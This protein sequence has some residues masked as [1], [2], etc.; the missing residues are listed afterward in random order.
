MNIAGKFDVS[1]PL[2]ILLIEDSEIDATLTLRAL[3]RGGFEPTHRR[4]QAAANVE[5]ALAQER[6]DAVISDFNMP[7]FSGLD[8]LAMFRAANLN[9][10]FI[11]VSGNIS[12]ETAVEAMKAGASDY[13]M[14]DKLARLAPALER[15]LKETQMRAAH[16]R[17]QRE[18]SESEERFREM[19]ENIRDVF[20]LIDAAS[21]RVLYI[22]PAYTG[23]W[24]R[25]PD[26]VYADAD[27]WRESIHPQ[28]RESTYD[29]FRKGMLDG[30]LEYEYRIVRPDGSIRWIETQGFPVRDSTGSMVRVAG[31][32]KDIT[33]RKA[34]QDRITYLNRVYAM[35]SGINTLIVRVRDRHELFREACR[36][37]VDACGFRMAWIAM[38]DR[39][40]MKVVPVASA[41]VDDE[42]LIALKDRYAMSERGSLGNTRAARAIS[43]GT[44]I[45]TNEVANNTS[46]A[47]GRKYA[48]RGIGSMAMLPLIV[49]GQAVGAL[50][51]YAHESAFFH[52]EE[53]KLLSDL[54]RDIAF[55]IEHIEKEEKIARL[56]R[57]QALMSGINAAIV[58]IQD[59][60][61]L[62]RETC[63]IAVEHGKFELV[64]VARVDRK[65]RTV[66]P[67]AWTG[68]SLEAAHA[69]DWPG[70]CASRGT[71]EKA[72]LTGKPAVR[73]DIDDGA[74]VGMLRQEAVQ[75]GCLSTVCLPLLVDGQVVALIALF[76]GGRGFFDKEELALLNEVSAKV[77]FALQAIDRTL[78]DVTERKR[79][80]TALRHLNEELEG[81]VM[82][83]TVDLQ[84][85][86][87]EAEEANRAKSSFLA[88]MSHEIRTPMNGVIGMIDVLHQS[89]LKSEQVEMVDLIR[90]SRFPCLASS[91][92]SL[93]SPKSKPAS[94]NSS[95][96]PSQ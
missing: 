92:T 44:P 74:P 81:K 90:D 66:Q 17:T 27:A 72:I 62:L 48:E 68:F 96:S 64:W 46:V 11:L 25:T 82:A 3:R 77:S 59:H 16:H 60:E 76:A 13:V 73:N 52:E 75:R 78:S 53:M 19:A 28:D 30:K 5:A 91:T 86:R 33:E 71:L 94:W 38:V 83:R 1:T 34:A 10:P 43:A 54:T 9:I 55:A 58:R 50:A 85:A 31:L 29:K 40:S 26:S 8:A 61:V 84:R 21:N 80:E 70:I 41:G 12:E 23:I 42:L 14:K 2:R 56:T 87:S 35:L 24:G 15:E 20:F 95:V 93:I 7:G 79:A 65:K 47:F 22:S 37:A 39:K 49:S 63:Q 18:L 88:A 89:S 57:I 36:I 67:V 4:V 6:W 45:V 51:L 32:A 69:V